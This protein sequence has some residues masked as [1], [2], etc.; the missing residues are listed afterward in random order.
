MWSEYIE[1][2]GFETVLE[3]TYQLRIVAVCLETP[4]SFFRRLEDCP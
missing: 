1:V 4:L 3:V 2:K